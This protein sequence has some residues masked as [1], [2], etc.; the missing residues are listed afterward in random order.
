MDGERPWRACQ[1]E[2]QRH[3]TGCPCLF[4]SVFIFLTGPCPKWDKREASVGCCSLC[5]CLSLMPSYTLE[6]S[7]SSTKSKG[8]HLQS[9]NLH[10]R[11]FKDDIQRTR[12]ISV[13]FS[14]FLFSPLLK[15]CHVRVPESV[16]EIIIKCRLDLS[17]SQL[18]WKVINA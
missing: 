2:D 17:E 6:D 5:L 14:F 9:S 10:A 18:V 16:N 4:A 8:H 3:L 7:Q 11:G 1:T 15:G 13:S 12:V